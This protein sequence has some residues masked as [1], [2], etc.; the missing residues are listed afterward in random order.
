M[1][2]KKLTFYD[3]E[4]YFTN[5]LKSMAKKIGFYFAQGDIMKSFPLRRW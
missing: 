4:P 2:T 5:S 1:R 3:E